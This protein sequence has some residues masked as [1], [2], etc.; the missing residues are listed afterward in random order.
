MPN[1]A[2]MLPFRSGFA[3]EDAQ[4]RNLKLWEAASRLV[5]GKLLFVVKF[6]LNISYGRFNANFHPREEAEN[7]PP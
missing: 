1:Q 2:V 6:Y 7:R 5:S 3:Y 4:V